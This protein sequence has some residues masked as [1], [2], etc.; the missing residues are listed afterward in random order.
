ME[1]IILLQSVASPPLDAL[2]LALTHLGSENAYIVMLLV[3]Y[4]AIDPRAGRL[5]GVA[6][7]GSYYLNQVAKDFV[8][9]A[10]PFVTDPLLVRSRAAEATAPGGA[11]PSGHA[12][13][14]A[15]FWGMVAPLARRAWLTWTSVLLIALVSLTRLYLGVH[16]PLDVA[17]GLILGS[18]IAVVGLYAARWRPELP[19]WS[20]AAAWLFFPLFAHLAWGT[21]DSGLIAGGMAGFATGGMVLR[22]R[23]PRAW[24]RRAVLA[25][26][27]LAL[28]FGW[29]LGTSLLLPQ[30]AKDHVLVEPLRYFVL[31]WTGVVVAP[32]LGVRLGLV[33]REGV[34]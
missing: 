23:P 1:I 8:D 25:V 17:G 12:Q 16:W 13:L 29:L 33:E 27:G 9:T 10:R 5:L 11:F 31:A 21:E 2:A 30:A 20:L 24:W 4:L 32:W 19:P 28:V 3:T 15:T 26:L 22:H 7:L 14:A 34:T 18:I 6:V